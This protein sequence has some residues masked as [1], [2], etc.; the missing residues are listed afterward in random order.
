MEEHRWEL[1]PPHNEDNSGFIQSGADLALALCLLLAGVTSNFTSDVRP[2]TAASSKSLNLLI[3]RE[4]TKRQFCV[5]ACCALRVHSGPTNVTE[6]AR[7]ANVEAQRFAKATRVEATYVC[8]SSGVLLSLAL[9]SP[10]PRCGRRKPID[11]N[12]PAV[13][14]K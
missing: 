5:L 4:F 1:T 14:V 11:S 3:D 9:T 8:A 6:A 7:R 12:T 10:C 2:A 13:P